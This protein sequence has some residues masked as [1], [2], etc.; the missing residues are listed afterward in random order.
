[1]TG[2]L[3]G[4]VCI[5]VGAGQQAGPTIGNGRATSI[6]FA[7]E[8]ARLLLVDRDADAVA[9]TA[10]EIRSGTPAAEIVTVTADIT[11]DD[12]PATIVRTALDAYGRIDVLHN[13]VGIGAGD[14][15]PHRL[16]DEVFDRIIDVNL[17]ALWRTCREVVPPMREQE[18][19][20]ITNVSSIASIAGN[21]IAAYRMSKAGVDALTK[22]LALTNARYGIRVN[23]ILPGLIDTPL[24]VDSAAAAMGVERD[25]LAARRAEAVPMGHQGTAWDVA[26]AALF[27]ASDEAAFISGVCLPVDGA[28]SARVG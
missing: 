22:N 20:V 8:G 11:A 7:Q 3:D 12:A 18:A 21:H 5:V 27:L 6:R 15:P 16:T 26:N 9:Q 28:Q 14:A 2:R 24:G 10:D 13:N 23:A 4:K 1:M 19:G 25:V 17:R